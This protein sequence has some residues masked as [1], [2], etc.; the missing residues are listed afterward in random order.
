MALDLE[1]AQL[2]QE[3]SAAAAASLREACGGA[4]GGGVEADALAS[5]NLQL[6]AAL[7]KLRDMSAA[8][9]AALSKKM[10]GLE[11]ELAAAT[12]A[13]EDAS[14]LR[15]WKSAKS[16]QLEELML[17]V[18]E[19]Q[20]YAGMVETLSD[21][22]LTL[23][24]EVHELR[25]AVAD[26]EM[27]MELSEELEQQQAVEI[28]TMQ[29]ELDSLY[30]KAHN[31]EG[32]LSAMKQRLEDAGKTA[33][34]FRRL[35]EQ[36]RSE[37][38]A[39]DQRLKEETS[40]LAS[41]RA[42]VE[43]RSQWAEKRALA[44]D[45]TAARAKHI[46]NALLGIEKAACVA[47][48][49]RLRLG[50]P[51][52]SEGLEAQAE[53]DIASARAAAKVWLA[54]GL[55]EAMALAFFESRTPGETEGTEE[56]SDL[57]GRAEAARSEALVAKALGNLLGRLWS[58]ASLTLLPRGSGEGK[59]AAELASRALGCV[60]DAERQV[61]D[62]LRVL[63]DEGEL[64]PSLAKQMAERLQETA[65]DLEAARCTVTSHESDEVRAC[66]SLVRVAGEVH[67]RAVTGTVTGADEAD[68]S[69]NGSKLKPLWELLVE[70]RQRL[71]DQD[72]EGAGP[73]GSL[74]IAGVESELVSLSEAEGVGTGERETLTRVLSQLTTL[75][76]VRLGPERLWE[77]A[78]PSRSALEEQQDGEAA[79]EVLPCID[80]ALETRKSM[81]AAVSLQPR[82][83]EAT[84]QVASLTADL[85]RR[86]KALATA[87][88]AR[89]E[90]QA[91]LKQ[92]SG[93][94]G[95]LADAQEAAAKA[96][97]ECSALQKEN[98]MMHEALEVIQG[99]MDAMQAEASGL[100]ASP[101]QPAGIKRHSSGASLDGAGKLE[102][103]D[104]AVMMASIKAAKA[105]AERWKCKASL[106]MLKSLKPLSAAASART[107]SS[108]SSTG[109]EP[110]ELVSA[111][112][113]LERC[114]AAIAR[115][116]SNPSVVKVGQGQDPRDDL[117][118]QRMLI[119]KTR[120][121]VAEAS[122][123]ARAAIGGALT[124]VSHQSFGDVV[125]PPGASAK[126]KAKTKVGTLSLGGHGETTIPVLFGEVELQRLHKA[127]MLQ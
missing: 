80:R 62:L 127:L 89:D 77:A 4:A 92:G 33:E 7:K 75:G 116:R 94:G 36:L 45:A 14:A 81:S 120:R 66:S 113:E 87:L 67:L 19:A 5:Q 88:A 37:R 84:A 13:A 101:Q 28:R 47:Q 74:D 122:S 63:K 39:L 95:D 30:V 57:E 8:E 98:A 22:N 65:R 82:L 42:R 53:G 69:V 21:K 55:L 2:L 78:A 115:L 17:Q 124:Q 73:A 34:R 32:E 70:A 126:A 12:N 85:V 106:S 3:E 18:D 25:A 23:G 117:V 35:T 114:G 119:A 16:A 38:D 112:Q 110:S 31:R 100:R 24:E 56:W 48:A 121:A 97:E 1:Q 41:A 9:K 83:T 102:A 107:N 104:E 52:S 15:E 50:L 71:I 76:R 29:A 43:Q 11:R 10:R 109:G 64:N 40:S 123:R 125:E 72:G 99:Q 96:K 49:E 46:E 86:D 91:L 111:W 68:A 90:L 118:A 51:E 93:S 103:A 58:V 108:S 6:R 59:A 26:L 20:A 61:D 54:V 60:Q 44:G 27:S 105:D 79:A